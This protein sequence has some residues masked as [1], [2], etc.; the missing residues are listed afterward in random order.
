MQFAAQVCG[1][2]SH[3][4]QSK[5]KLIVGEGNKRLCDEEFEAIVRWADPSLPQLALSPYQARLDVAAVDAIAN[6]LSKETT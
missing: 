2:Q 4:Q 6:K 3:V 5:A 1:S